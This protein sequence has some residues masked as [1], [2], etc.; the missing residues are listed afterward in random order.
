M[1]NSAPGHKAIL[2]TVALAFVL[3]FIS[4]FVYRVQNPSLTI[5]R[6][7]EQQSGA[8]PM[9]MIGQLMRKLEQDPKNVSTLRSLGRAFMSMQAWQRAASFWQRLLEVEP[10]N[11]S[12]AHQ[13]AMCYFRMEEY[14]QAVTVLKRIID[15]DSNDYYAHY[16]LGV[17]YK[18]YLDKA[19]K[20]EE[21]LQVIVKAK[22]AKEELRQEAQKELG[23]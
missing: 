9:E 4:S 13:L 15:I 12:A 5:Q 16:N 17:L 3:I 18:H 21:H 10:D 8:A 2:G 14:S 11:N 20:A 22:D 23:K 6:Q 7:V 19:D 1:S